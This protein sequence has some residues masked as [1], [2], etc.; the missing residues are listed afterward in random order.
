MT[1]PPGAALTAALSKAAELGYSAITSKSVL[2]ML[3]AAQ[4][5][6]AAAERQRI[7]RE[8][9]KR[10]PSARNDWGAYCEACWTEGGFRA[11]YPC[12]EAL[13]LAD[14]LGDDRQQDEVAP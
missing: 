6:Y 2:A 1:E 12:D 13:A 7:G 14:L 11:A 9:L 10:H 3:T 8:L 5:H 4:P